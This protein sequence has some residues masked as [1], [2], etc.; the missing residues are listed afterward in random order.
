M[1]DK[2]SECPLA[3]YT[4][5]GQVVIEADYLDFE[6]ERAFK[7]GDWAIPKCVALFPSD[8]VFLSGLSLRSHTISTILSHMFKD[9]HYLQKNSKVLAKNFASANCRRT[10]K[11]Q[12]LK[13]LPLT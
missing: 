9:L 10:L 2:W 13:F 5:L 12:G 8:C 3:K 11:T 1:Y 4:R 7:K 6:G